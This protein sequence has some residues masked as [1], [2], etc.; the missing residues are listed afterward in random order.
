MV[1]GPA[2]FQRGDMRPI[3]DDIGGVRLLKGVELENCKVEFNPPIV[4]P[5]TGGIYTVLTQD[6]F[7]SKALAQMGYRDRPKQGKPRS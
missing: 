3:Y 6:G 4:L 2:I 7:L 1:H 5:S